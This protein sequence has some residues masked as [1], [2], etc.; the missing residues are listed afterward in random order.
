M[1]HTYI[2][3]GVVDGA[4]AKKQAEQRASRKWDPEET[5]LHNHRRTEQC[6]DWC[7]LVKVTSDADS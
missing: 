1:H 5:W 7:Y 6:T 3:K 2:I 4:V